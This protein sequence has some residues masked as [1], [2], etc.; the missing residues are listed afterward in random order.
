MAKSDVRELYDDKRK[1]KFLSNLASSSNIQASALASDV[2]V[3]TVYYWR[4]HDDQ[5]RNEWQKALAIGYELLEAEMLDRARNG[6]ERELFHA[7]KLVSVVRDYDDAMAFRLLQAHRDLMART[8]AVSMGNQFDPSEARA[9]LDE[10]LDAL[11]HR[12]TN[13]ESRAVP[14]NNG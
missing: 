3:S 11:R 9:K 8:R 12:L 14:T 2:A 13:E 5:F 6:T 4:A 10:K 1:L 7:G